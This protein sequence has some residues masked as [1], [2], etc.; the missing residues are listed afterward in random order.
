M[1]DQ[2]TKKLARVLLRYCIRLKKKQLVKL[3]GS[4]QAIPLLRELYAEALT[5]GAYPYIKVAIEGLDEILLKTGSR[6][7][8]VYISP[9]AYYEVEKIDAVVGVFA[10]SNTKYLSG[11]NPDKQALMG[12]AQSKLLER[13]LTRAAKKQLAWVSTLF[14]ANASAQDAC[15]SLSDY[16]DFVYKACQ[17]DKKDPIAEW[18]KISRYNRQLI[19]YLKRKKLIHITALDTDLTF[20]VSGRKW[21]NCDGEN[22][23][24][25]G[26][27]FTAPLENSANGHIRF[28][29]PA[30]YRGREVNDVYI[31]FKN[32]KA[33]KTTSSRG[34]DFLEAMLNMDKGARYIGEVAIGTNYG[35]KVFTRNILFDE[36]IGGTF[37]LALGK[38]YPESG[39]KNSSALHWD[40]VCDL[41]K[42]G[43]MYADGEMFFKNGKFLR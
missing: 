10:P 21:I 17:I 14:P 24:P 33:I 41:R 18:R 38:A 13:L 40:M 36:K 27:V 22:N 37:H 20:S 5:I 16:E 9:L 39:G 26:E 32:G 12:K 4:E 25:D 29:Y 35:I 2:R 1:I 11:T 7:Q 19:N 42:D 8:L 15:M 28:S 43:C 3:I 31:E 6:D 23:F 30:V 34:Q